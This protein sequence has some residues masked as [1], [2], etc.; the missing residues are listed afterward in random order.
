MYSG[1]DQ[2]KVNIFPPGAIVDN[3][4]WTI[5]SPGYLDTLGYHN[6]EYVIQFG[7]MDIAMAALKVTE[8]ETTGGSYTDIPLADYSVSP[9]TLPSATDDNHLFSITIPIN[10]LRKRY[11]KIVA[12]GGDG[13]AGTYMSCIAI[14][15]NPDNAPYDATTRGYT[16]QLTVAG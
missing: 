16:Q 7:A 12:T 4:S 15:G 3:T 2:K 9:A 8:C 1:Q 6:V 13:S 14:L 11:Q 5:L 10:G